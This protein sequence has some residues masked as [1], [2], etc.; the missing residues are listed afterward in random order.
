V[1]TI[2]TLEFAPLASAGTQGYQTLRSVF[3]VGDRYTDHDVT[4]AFA[5][6]D[7]GYT[8][9]KT[10]TAATSSAWTEGYQFEISPPSSN[11]CERARVRF[12]DS[13]DLG[14]VSTGRGWSL[15]SI[16]FDAEPKAGP[17]RRLPADQRF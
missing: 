6:D 9:T 16:T 2:T 13:F 3:F 1:Y 11:K 15:S 5:Y 4:V 8:D 10:I 17:N 14:G 7:E 12:S